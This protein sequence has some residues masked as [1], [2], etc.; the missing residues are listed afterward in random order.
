MK[1]IKII[2]SV[3]EVWHDLI[4]TYKCQS[5]PRIGETFVHG[6]TNYKVTDVVH[7]KNKIS[8]IIKN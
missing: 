7:L 8:V 4:D 3:N 6:N 5:I 1:E 2:E